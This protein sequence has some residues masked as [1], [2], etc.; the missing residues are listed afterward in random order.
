MIAKAVASCGAAMLCQTVQPPS[1]WWHVAEAGTPPARV[2]QFIDTGTIIASPV[3]HKLIGTATVLESPLSS[4]IASAR[5]LY[6]VDCRLGR[7]RTVLATASDQSGGSLGTPR[8]DATP[9]QK[10][11]RGTVAAVISDAARRG[12]LPVD[13]IDIHDV[14]PTMVSGFFFGG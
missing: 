10:D 1:H 12:K 6:E 13:A 8:T 11:R 5:V 2:E 7:S 14:D 3:G 9:W 4:G